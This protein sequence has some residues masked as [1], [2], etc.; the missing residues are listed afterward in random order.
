[1]RCIKLGSAVGC[2]RV[3]QVHFVRKQTMCKSVNTHLTV[4]FA[5][6]KPRWL[7]HNTADR[8]EIVFGHLKCLVSRSCMLTLCLRYFSIKRIKVWELQTGAFC[9]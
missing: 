1:M 9:V 2:W 7:L 6:Y 5:F 4:C 8:A 3:S